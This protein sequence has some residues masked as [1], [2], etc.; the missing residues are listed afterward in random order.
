MAICLFE[1]F[2]EEIPARLQK[3]ACLQLKTLACA[4]LEKE[5][6]SHE[7]LET[8]VTA[9]RLALIVKGMAQ[10]QRV[11]PVYKKGPSI[12]KGEETLKKFCESLN[13]LP[14]QCEKEETK[15]GTFWKAYYTP[16]SK[17]TEELM[18]FLC[19]YILQMFFWPKRMRWANSTVSWIRPVR[20]LVCLYNDKPLI[21]NWDEQGIALQSGNCTEGHRLSHVYQGKKDDF[22]PV[23]TVETVEN[24]ENLLEKNFVILC[25]LK[26]DKLIK[27]ALFEMGNKHGYRPFSE[28]IE[29]G[30]LIDEVVGLVEWPEGILGKFEEKFLDLPEP[31]IATTIKHHQKCFPF[32]DK[33][34]SKLVPYFGIIT[35][36]M[37]PSKIMKQGYE[38]VVQARLADALFF[39]EQDKKIPLQ[40]YNERLKKRMLFGGIGSIYD[41][42]KR[43]DNLA[44]C[45]LPN[46][47]STRDIKALQQTAILSKA[48]LETGVVGEFPTLQGIMGRY[49]AQAQGV[50]EDIAKAIEEQYWPQGE[51][52]VENLEN[53]SHLGRLLGILDR[54]DTLVGFFALGKIPSGSKDPFGLRRAVY[55]LVKLLLREPYTFSIDKYIQASLAAYQA[56]GFLM[57]HTGDQLAP[58]IQ[59]FQEKVISVFEEEGIKHT[60]FHCA[61]PKGKDNLKEIMEWARVLQELFSK[62]QGK[63]FLE[64]YLRAFS[65]IE[66]HKGKEIESVVDV[67]LFETPQEAAL[68][69]LTQSPL[70]IESPIELR[71]IFQKHACKG[72][73]A[74]NDFFEN[75]FVMAPSCAKNRLA[76]LN[77]VI[78]L[79]KAFGDLSWL[80]NK[81]T[82]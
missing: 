75:V 18:P 71:D 48:D 5:G 73:K 32:K 78:E 56:Q 60:F 59:F 19:N 39:W 82:L 68:Y 54:L 47:V 22:S 36:T 21:W 6:I 70:R 20:H 1:I 64:A 15:K 9:R 69:A 42:V 40:A 49:Y 24:Y 65:I 51:Q 3:Q 2:S 28:D 44:C 62:E 10:A 67:S 55:G 37:A 23:L 52:H 35:N 12:E 25:P 29:E 8:Y 41:K 80:S 53:Q 31:L 50:E 34:T 61:S 26:R 13:I 7:G 57:Q 27:E 74:L 17:K 81:E 79:F 46:A 72:T 16:V 58:L 14:E 77:Q 45:S 66:K 11:N 4:F 63:K 38:K 43:L 76:L 33:K 30:G